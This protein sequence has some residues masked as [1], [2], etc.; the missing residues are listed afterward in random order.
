MKKAVIVAAVALGL[1]CY[2]KPT[3]PTYE[4][5]V[6]FGTISCPVRPTMTR[7]GDWSYAECKDRSKSVL[8]RAA[9]RP[10][11]ERRES[12]A[13]R[14]ASSA[15]IAAQANCAVMRN[16]HGVTDCK[17]DG[18][19]RYRYTLDGEVAVGRYILPRA[20]NLLVYLEVVATD[21]E[22]S[23]AEKYFLETYRLQNGEQ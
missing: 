17:V 4:W 21:R 10:H 1:G 11:W 12:D 8:Y 16:H 14:L 9:C 5:P 22:P 6:A 20:Y 3:W 7:E 2:Q 15:V 18:D 13:K 19:G 23:R